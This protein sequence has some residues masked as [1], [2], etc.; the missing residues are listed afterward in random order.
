M[1]VDIVKYFNSFNIK[2]LVFHVLIR[3]FNKNNNK[4]ITHKIIT[5]FIDFIC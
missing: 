4:I 1:P 3:K 2:L 5:I